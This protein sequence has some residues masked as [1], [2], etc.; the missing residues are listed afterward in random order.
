MKLQ[1]AE[2]VVVALNELTDP[3][4]LCVFMHLDHARSQ[5]SGD[6]SRMIQPSPAP[7]GGGLYFIQHD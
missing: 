2:P 3:K 1:S 4:A 5:R 7:K 6:L